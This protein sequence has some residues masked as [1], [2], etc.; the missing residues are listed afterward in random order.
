MG[1]GRFAS[2]RDTIG[3]RLGASSAGVEAD[4]PYFLTRMA[5]VS[6]AKSLM[7]YHCWLLGESGV[8]KDDYVLSVRV[9]VTSLCPCSKEISDFGAHNQRSFLTIE[10]RS[11]IRSDGTVEPMCMEDFIDVA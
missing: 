4:F 9:P 2:I 5:P 3:G 8:N 1:I 11:K 10:A 6:G 7:N